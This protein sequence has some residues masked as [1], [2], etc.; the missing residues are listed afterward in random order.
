MNANKRI[1]SGISIRESQV[2]K[3]LIQRGF[4]GEY[5]LVSTKSESVYYNKLQTLSPETR[6]IVDLYTPILLEKELTLSK[7]KPL[8]WLTR[9]R[10]KEMVRKFLRRG[11]HFLVANHRQREYWVKM[12]KQL[13]VSV[14]SQRISVFPT[15]SSLIINHQPL[16]IHNRRVVLWFGGIYPWM[17]PLP[18]IEAFGKIAPK[19]PDWKLRFLGGWHP[20]TGYKGIYRKL[21]ELARQKIPKHQLEFVPWQVER[22]LSKYFKDAAFAVHLAKP[23]CED[24]YAHRVRLLTLFSAGIPVLTSGRDIISELAVRLGAAAR[25]ELDRDNVEKDLISLINSV[26]QLD[27]MRK[28]GLKIEQTFLK[29]ETDIRLDDLNHLISP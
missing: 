28:I 26:K 7:W 8:D 9:L 20:E 19:F 2:K 27:K 1:E 18:L 5:L 22:N 23:T 4:R 13:G 10:N 6:L 25:T 16:T 29:Q 15:G 17:D 21:E 14:N 11:N 24:Y 3:W 12:S